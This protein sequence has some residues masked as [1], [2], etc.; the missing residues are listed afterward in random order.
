VVSTQA[1]DPSPD[2]RPAHSSAAL[3]LEL[4]G[5]SL[6]Q[7]L[8]TKQAP[9]SEQESKH[10]VTIYNLK[11]EVHVHV[12]MYDTC[13]CIQILSQKLNRSNHP[14]GMQNPIYL[15]YHTRYH[16]HVLLH[17][18]IKFRFDYL[19]NT[20]AQNVSTYMYN[21]HCRTYMHASHLI[22]TITDLQSLLLTMRVF[23]SA[24]ICVVVGDDGAEGDLS[25]E[26]VDRAR[27]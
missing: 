20:G 2:G 8:H 17:N 19:Q 11:T 26:K 24:T 25:R 9:G 18:N 27:A 14:I 10:W 13:V 23:S 12:H 6:G 22:I 16:T 1:A 4:L 5:R 15:S 21:V 3:V 7:V